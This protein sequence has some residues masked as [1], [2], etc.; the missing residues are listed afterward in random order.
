MKQWRF[1]DQGEARTSSLEKTY[2]PQAKPQ[3]F[4][5]LLHLIG[6][7]DSAAGR[8]PGIGHKQRRGTGRQLQPARST[9]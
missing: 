8:H 1:I 9:I 5:R 4:C 2:K 3:S 7:G 6:A